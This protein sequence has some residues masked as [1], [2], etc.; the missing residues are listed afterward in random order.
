MITIYTS[1]NSNSSRKAKVW[2]HKYQLPFVEQNVFTTPPS[3]QD[4]KRILARTE[5]GTADIIATRSKAYRQLK[6]RLRDD[7]SLRQ[8][9]D[10]IKTHPGLLR[11]PLIID[12]RRLQIGYNS[13]DIR[14]FLPRKLRRLELIEAQRRVNAA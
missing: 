1:H 2:L 13:D 4:F 14:Q 3:Y 6:S 12:E 11:R 8:L 10:L 7:L 5:N 9:Y